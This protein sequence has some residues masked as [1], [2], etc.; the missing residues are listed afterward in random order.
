[1]LAIFSTLFI[2]GVTGL[3][4]ALTGS[5][6]IDLEDDAGTSTDLALYGYGYLTEYGPSTSSLSSMIPTTTASTTNYPTTT[7]TFTITLYGP[8]TTPGFEASQPVTHQVSRVMMVTVTSQ[9]CSETNEHGWTPVTSSSL[10]NS[11]TA[12]F[13]QETPVPFRSYE[14]NSLPCPASKGPSG[15]GWSS[16]NPYRTSSSVRPSDSHGWSSTTSCRPS[17]PS[18][19]PGWSMSHGD[20]SYP[21][22]VSH[23][24]LS[25]SS[26]T[27]SSPTKSE[28]TNSATQTPTPLLP[29][30][31]QS[32][33]SGQKASSQPGWSAF[34]VIAVAL[35]FSYL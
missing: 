22:S 5:V 12:Q 26:P 25:Q 15:S 13:G 23:G 20:L 33:G 28:S 16:T 17:A 18:S 21:T 3:G 8:C 4:F 19:L 27:K 29:S 6:G 1:M 34:A 11:S 35:V 24:G 2:A 31:A 10:S 32:T 14:M 30:P 9:L 7:R